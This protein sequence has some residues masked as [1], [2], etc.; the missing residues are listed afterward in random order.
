M[1]EPERKARPKNYSYKHLKKHR[2]Q[3]RL[4]IEGEDLTLIGL[5]KGTTYRVEVNPDRGFAR[6]IVDPNGDRVVSGRKRPGQT[7]YKPI[8][9]VCLSELAPAGTRVRA[10][11]YQGRIEVTIHHEYKQM[12]DRE[13][14]LMLNLSKNKLRE[15]VLCS[16]IGISAAATQQGLAEENIHADL[17]WVVEM[18]DRYNDISRRNNP[19]ITDDTIIFSGT[20]EEIEPELITPVDALQMS[21]PC[22]GHSIAGVSSRGLES[23]EDHPDSATS[24]F[25][26]YRILDAANPSIIWSENVI[27]ARNSS[28]YKLLVQE[29]RRR[30][31]IV[32]DI[33]LD[34]EQ[35]GSVEAR[36]RWYFVAISKG[37]AE[38]FD[39]DAI[40]TVPRVYERVRDAL[41]HV[42]L[43]DERWRSFPGL[44]DK[45]DRDLKSKKGFRQAVLTGDEETIP[46]LRKYYQRAG[47]TDPRISMIGFLD[48][49]ALAG[50]RDQILEYGG[51]DTKE[52]S[53]AHLQRLI[54]E[55]HR[56]LTRDEMG[57]IMVDP[58]ALELIKERLVMAKEHARIK[59]ISMEL[60]RDLSE[61]V[62][63]EGMGQAGLHGHFSG[64]ARL[65]GTHLNT[66]HFDRSGDVIEAAFP[67]RRKDHDADV[68]PSVAPTSEQVAPMPQRRMRKRAS[69]EHGAQP[70]LFAE[71]K[72]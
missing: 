66:L 64:L 33:V 59:G 67:A 24:L 50:I 15:A 5:T 18:D 12:L 10:A 29:L 14:R 30:N 19:S 1:S 17:E 42:P 61:T 3:H 9:D 62:A 46:T 20:L 21:L 56:T 4:W 44:Y 2:N 40:Q 25:G 55:N 69:M 72:L 45:A 7:E 41:D 13:R 38:G 11:L 49:D 63:H 54:D 16:G 68:K 70:D 32:Q 27:Q 53:A 26:A 23:A 39:I 60:I 58:V 47:S 37:I 31:Y 43:D 35:A 36:R 28:T 57:E 71:M 6:L 8:I 48:N 52:R 22:D 51:A 34:H 65:V